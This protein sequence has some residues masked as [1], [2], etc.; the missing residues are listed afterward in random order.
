MLAFKCYSWQTLGCFT[1]NWE[2]VKV[3][4]VYSSKRP[5]GFWDHIVSIDGFRILA[6][7]DSGFHVKIKERLT[8]SRDELILMIFNIV[9]LFYQCKN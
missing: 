6:T 9:E 3:Q 4:K 1:Y 5:Y 7:S 2:K 8:V